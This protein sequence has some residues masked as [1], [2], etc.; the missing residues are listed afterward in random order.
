MAGR[1]WTPLPLAGNPS[2]RDP[3]GAF[4][5]RGRLRTVERR[6]REM[7]GA[8]TILEREAES[9]RRQLRQAQ[10]ANARSEPSVSV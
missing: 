1:I 3:G 10:N 7:R 5:L 8:V 6:I 9:L 4:E 2:T